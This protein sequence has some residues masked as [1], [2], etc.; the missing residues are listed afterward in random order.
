MART[1]P[2]D[3]AT[4]QQ[5]AGVFG[6]ETSAFSCPKCGGVQADWAVAQSLFASLN[7]TLSELQAAVKK[8]EAVP[9]RTDPMPCPACSNG[10]LKPFRVKGVELD[11][12]A[13]CGATWFDRS[14]LSRI[15]KGRLGGTHAEI[16]APA[17]QANERVV[18]VYE[19][20][21]DCAY[22]DTKGLLG[23]SNRFCPQCGAAQDADRRYFPPPG[24]EV[25]SNHAFDGADVTCPACSTPNGV[26]AVHCRQCGSPL[27]GSVSVTQLTDRGSPAPAAMALASSTG[28]RRKWPWVVGVVGAMLVSFCGV[29]KFWTKS[30]NATVTSHRWSRSIDVEGMA[31]RP[32]SSWCDSMPSDA[33][34]VSRHREQRSTNRIPDGQT[35]ST[36]DVDRGNGTFERRQE[37]TTKYREEPVYDDRCTYTVNRW[38][39]IRT[40][41]SAGQG[42]AM[43]PVWPAVKLGALGSCLGC[44]RE[45]PRHE[46][47]EL[48]LEGPKH[49]PWSCKI[50]ASKWQSLHDGE[51]HEVKVS[52]ILGSVDCSS[53]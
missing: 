28:R 17:L 33:Y 1:C 31:A 37:C 35:C 48:T 38:Q 52:V 13:D 7:L 14:E 5:T 12:C 4:L 22:C 10:Q 30:A 42:L 29:A 2:R 44:E 25:A 23:A 46:S 36:R 34:G 47:Y 20:L 3:G 43:E 11:L 19:M 26:K 21:W 18:G 32:D 24:K 6:H 41:N 49:E 50:P 51:S 9:G 15:T 53:L 40:L 16:A 45:G 39:T 8:A 27:D